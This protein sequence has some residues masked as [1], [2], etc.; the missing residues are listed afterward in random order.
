MSNNIANICNLFIIFYKCEL[1]FNSPKEIIIEVFAKK[2]Y[3]YKNLY[4]K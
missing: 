4:S 2:C 1:I 3:M